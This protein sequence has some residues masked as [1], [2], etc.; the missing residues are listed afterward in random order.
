MVSFRASDLV[1]KTIGVTAVLFVIVTL[2]SGG[3][4]L[5]VLLGG[6]KTEVQ[7]ADLRFRFDRLRGVF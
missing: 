7:Q 3:N 5:F 4:A 6:L 2:I 1:I